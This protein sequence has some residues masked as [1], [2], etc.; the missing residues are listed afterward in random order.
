M[1]ERFDQTPS[2]L[3]LC[4]SASFYMGPFGAKGEAGEKG[5]QGEPGRPAE[6]AGPKGEQGPPGE[7]G[8]PGPKASCECVH[9]RGSESACSTICTLRF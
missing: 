9:V 3:P 4:P 7:R 8:I 5:E 2:N 6:S 1:I